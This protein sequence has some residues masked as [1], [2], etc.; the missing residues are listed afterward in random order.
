MK[1]RILFL[2]S[3]MK[4]EPTG[5]ASHMAHQVPSVTKSFITL[6]TWEFP[7]IGQARGSTAA[8][9]GEGRGYPTVTSKI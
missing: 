1:S 6:C 8:S 2:F 9:G 7:F 3:M 4:Y 5:V